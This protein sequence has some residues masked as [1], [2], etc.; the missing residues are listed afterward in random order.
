MTLKDY[1]LVDNLEKLKSLITEIKAADLVAFDTETN[2]LNPR[3]GKIIGVSFS[4]A[5]G[6]GWYIPTLV[7]NLNTDGLDDFYIE[8]MR[9]YDIAKKTV[10]LLV[11]KKLIGHNFS[12]D[13]KF[14]KNYFGIDLVPSIWADTMLLVHTVSEEGA[15]VDRMTKSFALK[16]I[17]KT[18]QNH[19]G[20]DVDKEANEEQIELKASIKSNLG[21]T[22][23]ENYEIYKADL[24][25]LS[26]YACA[27]TDLALRVFEY[28]L[29][30]IKEQGLY[31][32]FFFDEV[33]PLYR[34]VTIPMEDKGVKLDIELIKSSR[35]KIDAEMIKYHDMVIDDLLGREEVQR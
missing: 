21:S 7:Y 25:I 5:E 20:I 26:K 14:V 3:K 19:I 17:A 22:S 8:D 35:E 23:K 31:D 1:V 34:E 24:P 12:F 27:D 13:A 9:G 18:V 11:G 6:N 15:G 16:N 28:Y 30:K 10:S 29:Q 2:S 4:T 32:F 33:M